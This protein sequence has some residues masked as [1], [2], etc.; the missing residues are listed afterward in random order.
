MISE[1]TVGFNT[2]FLSKFFHSSLD[3]RRT[4]RGNIRHSFHDILLVILTGVLCGL[5]D[6]TLI[7]RFA[8]REMDWFGAH[9]DFANGIPSHETL[10]RFMAALDP[11]AF[12]ECFLGWLSTL[13]DLGDIGT[14][15][16]DGKVIKGASTKSDPGSL[17]PHVLTA[18]ATGQGI[19]LGQ[20]RVDDKSNEITAMPELLK[21]I[22]VAGNT[23]TIDAMGCQ[24]E[25]VNGIRE[26]GGDYVIAVKGN[27]GTLEQGIMDTARLE[28]PC[29]SSFTEDLGH[30]RAERRT[31][32]VYTDLSHLGNADKWRDLKCLVE[33]TSLVHNKSTGRT[34]TEKRRYITS[35][36]Q[37]A[38][39]LNHII[40][41]HWA[42]ENEL[43]WMLDVNFGEDSSRK[44]TGNAPL[45]FNLVFK[46]ALF[47]LKRDKS[48]KKSI[49]QKRFEALIDVGY[50]NK[51]LSF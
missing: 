12:G 28:R 23:I 5:D 40:R 44:R 37:D 14:L 17:S 49:K 39:K 50:R 48:L 51:L 43:H 9:G 15:A 47:L 24:R 8:K 38:E 2:S 25:T 16:I 32:N 18:W 20:V 4:D 46:S 3:M 13:C 41:R 1:A 22:P 21:K 35:L 30:G 33:V 36:G 45:N 31:C 10:R 7:V 29:A 19:S 42:I 26:R 27:Q 6:Y 34:T 11:E